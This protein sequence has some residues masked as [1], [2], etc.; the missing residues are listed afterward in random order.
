[1]SYSRYYC[2]FDVYSLYA[3]SRD[4]YILGAIA[5]AIYISITK[6][7]IVVNIVT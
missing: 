2:F 6:I 5:M 1:M 3:D 4:L 7:D